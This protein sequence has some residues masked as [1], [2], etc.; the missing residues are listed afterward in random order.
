[1]IILRHCDLGEKKSGTTMTLAK[2][3]SRPFPGGC[4]L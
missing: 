4:A 2:V 3:K 1:M